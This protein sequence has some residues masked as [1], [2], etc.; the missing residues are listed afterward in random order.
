MAA[1]VRRRAGIRKSN[2]RIDVLDAVSLLGDERLLGTPNAL[3]CVEGRDSD[4]LVMDLGGVL[5]EIG[6]GLSA[7]VSV[8]Q[9]EVQRRD[10]VR[11]VGA[12]ELHA[13]GDAFG[14]VVSHSHDCIGESRN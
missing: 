14:G 11:A 3:L 5:I 1:K 2:K 8:T 13:S 6:G 7:K 10:A 12:G 4:R 9:I